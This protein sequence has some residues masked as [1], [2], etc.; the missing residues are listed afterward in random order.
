[1]RVLFT[2]APEP[3]SVVSA[4][5]AWLPLAL[6]HLAGAVR[7]AG[8]E[9]EV[10]DSLSMGYGVPELER[11]LQARADAG[12]SR[13]AEALERH[14]LRSPAW[15]EESRREAARW[16]SITAWVATWS[17]DDTHTRNEGESVDAWVLRQCRLM[18]MSLLEAAEWLSD[19]RGARL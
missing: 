3:G 12:D 16:P 10:V 14:P 6:V 18:G 19:V 15:V 8:H 17:L 7:A 4:A 1:M 5:D 13:A 9:C 2:S 11:V